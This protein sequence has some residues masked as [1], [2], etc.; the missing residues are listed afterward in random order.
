[1]R[2]LVDVGQPLLDSPIQRLRELGRE[3][4]VLA[5][6]YFESHRQAGGLGEFADELPDGWFDR[7]FLE[8][9]CPKGRNGAADVL[10][11]LKG[12]SPCTTYMLQRGLGTFGAELLRGLELDV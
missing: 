4:R 10:Q 1:M 7:Q 3:R 8:R 9:R 6:F 2:M 11:T 12:Q 5:K